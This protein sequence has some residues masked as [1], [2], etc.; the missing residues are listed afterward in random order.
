MSWTVGS[1]IKVGAAIDPTIYDTFTDVAGTLITAHVGE[2]GATWTRPVT[3]YGTAQAVIDAGRLHGDGFFGYPVASASPTSSEYIIKTSIYLAT[4]TPSAPNAQVYICFGLDTVANHWYQM[5]FFTDTVSTVSVRFSKVVAGVV[6]ALGNDST[7]AAA[8]GDTLEVA[9]EVRDDHKRV[10]VNGVERL[11]F[12]ETAGTYLPSPGRVGVQ[13]AQGGSATIGFHLN[14]LRTEPFPVPDNRDL[15]F[16]RW[17]GAYVAIGTTAPRDL[18]SVL[19]TGAE[20]VVMQAWHVAEMQALKAAA[21]NVKVFVYKDLIAVQESFSAY[22]NR[23]L[24]S[25]GVSKQEAE[26]SLS[27]ARLVT[28][29]GVWVTLSGWPNLY[30]MDP[31]S[32]A[33]RAAWVAN[34]LEELNSYGWDGVFV[35]DTNA[36]LFASPARPTAYPTNGPFATAVGGFLSYIST[37]LHLNKKLIFPNFGGWSNH[38]NTMD[39]WI[40]SVD[41]ALQEHFVSFAVGANSLQGSY[42]IQDQ[43]DSA[44]LMAESEKTWVGITITDL[45]AVARYAYANSLLAY[46][47]KTGFRF[48]ITDNAGYGAV[49]WRCVEQDYDIGKPASNFVQNPIYVNVRYFTKGVVVVNNSYSSINKTLVGGP[50]SGSGLTSVTAVTLAAQ[51]AVVLVKD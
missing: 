30:V 21:P 31:A 32:T 47:G 20:V 14:Y 2:V 11:K 35:D 40:P 29:L 6:T 48:E 24:W 23:N 34:V 26:A 25:T 41:Y 46:R 38:K 51:T 5:E 44:R 39:P 18:A 16:S 8:P 1:S 22:G 12:Y 27:A 4:M 50:Y 17:A 15:A 7:F 19:A 10:V 28:S 33:Y 13:F 3:S 42:T 36:E 9:I 49:P 37:Q 43:V 45:P